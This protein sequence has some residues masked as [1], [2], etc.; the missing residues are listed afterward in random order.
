MDRSPT[1]TPEC[2]TAVRTARRTSFDL[3]SPA[4]AGKRGEPASASAARRA[5]HELPVLRQPSHGRHAG[6]QP[7]THPAADAHSGY[8]SSLSETQLESSGTGSPDLPV[9]V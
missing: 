9:L 4:A 3:L 5:V 2:S 7:Q 8:R 6:G 1:S